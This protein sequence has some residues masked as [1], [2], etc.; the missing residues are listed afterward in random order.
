MSLPT[1]TP[2][3]EA[4]LLA[5]ATDATRAATDH[6]RANRARR[7]EVVQGFAHDVKLSLD[8]ECQQIAIGRIRARFPDHAFL[9]EEQA[10][11]NQADAPVAGFEW[12]IDPIDG[13]VNFSHGLPFWCCSIA[14]RLNG[15]TLAGAVHAAD[16]GE[17][18]TATR[19]GPALCNGVPLAV[20]S[21]TQLSAAMVMTGLDQKVNPAGERFGVFRAIA[22]SVQK[23]RIMGV[24]ALDLCRVA[25]GQAEGYFESGIYTWDIAAAGL[26]VERA[27]GRSEILTRLGPNRWCFMATNGRIHEPLKTLIVRGLGT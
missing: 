16:F 12:V 17:L 10:D 5:A 13:T 26:I 3:L 7:H 2:E 8:T 6:A 9:A 18:Y 25:A 14:V 20:S 1:V 22:D 21:V 24:A 27:G 15:V 4:Q 19:S 23:T 11:A